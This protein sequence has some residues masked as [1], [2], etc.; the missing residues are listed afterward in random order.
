MRGRALL[1][2]ALGG[3][4]EVVV[5]SG[6]VALEFDAIRG[7]AGLVTLVVKRRSCGLC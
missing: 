2:G 3:R 7:K 5:V 4:G 6:L 1:W